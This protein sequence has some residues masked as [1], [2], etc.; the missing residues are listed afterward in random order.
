MIPPLIALEEHFDSRAFE[1]TDELHERLPTHLHE[2]LEDIHDGRI[3]D[4]DAGEINLQVVSHIGGPT[5]VEGCIKAND[6]LA[7]AC[8]QSRGR[9]AGLAVLP[10]QEP[11]AAAD[12]L[13]R[14]VKEH[15]FLGALI[16]NHC[17][18]GSMYDDEKFWPMFERAV[19]LDVPIYIHPTYPGTNL[20]SHYS[21]NFSSMAAIMMSTAGWGWHSDCG[22][23]ILRLFA[24]GLFDR[25][26]K[27]KIVIGHMGEM[28][29]YMLDR[30][31]HSTRHWGQFERDLRT[32]WK[33]NIWVTTSGLFTLPPFEC[34]LKIS[35]M[36]KIMYSVD[37]PF[38]M[39]ET[40]LRFVEEI[41]RSGLL[42]GEQLEAFCHGNA[43]KLLKIKTPRM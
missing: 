33:E 29:P 12:E 25:F 14:T 35:P 16:N 31:C 39:G 23:H 43:E 5:P 19:A 30:I 2:R 40:G 27:L 1:G 26:P 9:L 41:E 10:T 34:L 3:K 18:D 11:A 8:R 37:Y 28:L 21:G 38:S 7:A 4:L 32:V 36:D 17:E 24:S 42:R 15:G 20:S 22:L 6:K 13:E